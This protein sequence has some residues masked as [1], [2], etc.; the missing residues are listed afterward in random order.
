MDDEHVS[1]EI[2]SISDEA[3]L[4]GRKLIVNGKITNAAMLLLGDEQY[5]YMMQN[6]P[7]ASWRVYDSKD[8]VKD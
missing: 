6:M 1:V 3:F 8:M 2:D 4:E 5:D 7:E